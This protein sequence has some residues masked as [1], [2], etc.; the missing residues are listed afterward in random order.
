MT[1]WDQKAA[2]EKVENFDNL[3][4]Q[5][6]KRL[7]ERLNHTFPPERYRAH[8]DAR[9]R[10][11]AHMHASRNLL[12]NAIQHYPP[13]MTSDEL[14]P[15]FDVL[16]DCAV[17]LTAGGEGE[18]L[19]KSLEENGTAEEHLRDFTKATFP[20][21]DF[22]ED[23]GALHI[24]L[25]ILAKICR[26]HDLSIP[27]IVST[28]PRGSTTS[29]VIPSIVERFRRA[30]LPHL[31]TIS[32]DERLHLT[33]D[34]KI[35]WQ[36]TQDGE[37]LPVTHPDET[38][39]PIMR[40]K[41]P[42]DNYPSILTWLKEKGSRTVLVLQATALYDTRIILDMAE[43]SLNRDCVGVGIARDSFPADDPYGTFV[44]I[45]RDNQKKIH[46]V[47]Q[48]VRNDQTRRI[49]DPHAGKFLPYNTGFYAFDID[50]LE[51]NDLPD[52]ATPPKEILP[53]LTRS[54]K[55]GYAATDLLP[56][57]NNPVILTVNPFSFAVIK[58]ADDLPRLSSLARSLGLEDACRSARELINKPL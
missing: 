25:A 6:Q 5:Q 41:Q 50:L 26:E 1:I 33:V 31:L 57:A 22:F 51:K 56:L 49:Q 36:M 10:A 16:R 46:I 48:A 27:V 34:E 18:R 29:R 8:R 2:A 44:E 12:E 55:A 45:E 39:G 9:L 52:Y 13:V 14:A 4:L 54:P 30:G 47:E 42:F 43:A 32:Q 23:F 37:I 19:R 11:E 38:G 53:S 24:N 17:L 20:L 3:D 15:T 21:P 7:I 58:N 28:G 35:A 40:L